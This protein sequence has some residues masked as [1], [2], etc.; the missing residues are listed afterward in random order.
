MGFPDESVIVPESVPW[1]LTEPKS[2]KPQKTG[3][4]V[5]RK[6]IVTLLMD[7]AITFLTKISY[8]IIIKKEGAQTEALS[9]L[10]PG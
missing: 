10:L 5:C 9:S 6:L 4:M 7:I 3:R 2:I 1:A 8:K